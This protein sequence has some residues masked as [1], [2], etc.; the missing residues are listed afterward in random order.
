MGCC[1]CSRKTDSDNCC[2]ECESSRNTGNNNYFSEYESEKKEN[3]K[4]KKKIHDL[5]NILEKSNQESNNLETKEE[6]EKIYQKVIEENE[7]LNIELQL[8]KKQPIISN[9]SNN[10]ND[11]SESFS[12]SSESEPNIGIIIQFKG[13]SYDFKIKEKWELLKVLSKFKRKYKQDNLKPDGKFYFKDRAHKS[14]S[15]S[16]KCEDLGVSEGTVLL[17]E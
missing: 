13:K 10:G 14:I 16:E 6:L 12:S 4:L 7:R 11:S 17:L 3:E 9:C 8:S 5:E 2:S 1:Q 15:L